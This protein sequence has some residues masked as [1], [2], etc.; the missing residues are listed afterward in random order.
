MP[1]PINRLLKEHKL[2]PKSLKKAF[3]NDTLESRPKVKKLVSQIRDTIQNGINRNRQDYRLFKAM[4]WAYDTPFYQVSYTQLKG[5]LSS[6]PDE[7]KVMEA[8]NSWGLT[9]M[10]PD[11]LNPDGSTCCDASTGKPRKALNLPVFFNIFVPIVMAYITIRWAKLFNDR[12]LVPFYKYEPVT[13][14]KENRFRCEVITQAVQ[15]QST[16]FD[17]PADAKQ[18]YLQTL[19][20]GFCINFPR[21]A[22]YVERQEDDSGKEKIVREGLRWNMPHPSRVYYDLYHRLSS[23]NSNSGCEYAGY[24]E[25]ARYRDIAENELYWNKDK[26]TMGSISWFDLQTNPDFLA[27]VFP[28]VMSFPSAAG[29]GAGGVGALDRQNEAAR[30]YGNGDYDT[31]TLLTQH[32]QRVIPKDVGLGSYAY[33]IWMRFVYASDSAVIWA[34]PLAYT[35]LPTYTYD[36]DFNRARFRSLALEIVPFQDHISNLLSQWILAVKDNLTNPVFY[37]KEKIP[38]TYVKELQNLGQKMLNGRLFIPFSSTENY[39]FKIDQREALYSPAL[40][41]HPTSES[42]A[43]INGVLTMLDRIMQLSPQEVGQAAPHE[44]TAEETRVIAGNTSTRVTF[45]GS[46]LDSGDYAKKVVLY[47]G[48]MAHADDDIVVGITSSFAST[49]EE[50]DKLL[51]AVGFELTDKEASFDPNEPE[52]MYEVKGNKAGLAIESFASTRDNVN[53]I[54]LPAVADAMSKIFI[55]IA[56]N[57]VLIQAIGPVQLV[58]L[59]NQIIVS[60]GVPQEFRLR[61]QAVTGTP[62]EQVNK[63]AEMMKGFAEQV[64]QL[65]AEKQQETLQASAQQTTQIVGQAMQAAQQQTAAVVAQGAQAASAQLQQAG[66]AIQ[67]AQEAL[68]AAGQ[69][70][71]QLERVVARQQQEIV[72][73]NQA[74]QQLTEAVQMAQG[75]ALAGQPS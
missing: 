25:L 40:T 2:D 39:R 31:A 33:P 11:M 52:R 18:T 53:R 38:A 10:L 29:L 5:L 48:L 1:I 66:P 28:C 27:Q 20:Y 63:T 72:S 7:K 62:E 46:G 4:D 16:W 13:F 41:H 15:K 14:T 74:V 68:V 19:L 24:W 23:L 44:Q 57:P 6:S 8:V 30:T 61:G 71:Q 22:W 26:I 58:E 51:K 17:Y 36:A 47:D 73:L 67:A 21:E 69:K 50:F 70:Q 56:G 12:N 54:N 55:A 9:H 3:D 59:L 60:S 37:D 35:M 32:F 42:Q 64:K 43:L 45:T 65:V 75:S 34:E 49:Q